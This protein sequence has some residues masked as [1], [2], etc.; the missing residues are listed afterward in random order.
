M[1]CPVMYRLLRIRI[2]SGCRAA[3]VIPPGTPLLCREQPESNH[4]QPFEL[5][6]S[7]KKITLRITNISVIRTSMIIAGIYILLEEYECYF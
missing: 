2:D 3:S 4:L 5:D 6:G 1:T 7:R